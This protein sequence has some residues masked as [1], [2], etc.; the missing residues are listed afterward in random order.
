MVLY[1]SV[2]DPE[3]SYRGTW[4]LPLLGIQSTKATCAIGMSALMMCA[5]AIRVLSRVA[6]NA[7]NKVLL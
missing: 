1:M 2:M 3:D 4:H 5:M 6:A 7:R